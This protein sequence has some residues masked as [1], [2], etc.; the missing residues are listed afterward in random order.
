M[1]I[2]RSLFGHF[3]PKDCSG[4]PEASLEECLPGGILDDLPGEQVWHAVEPERESEGQCGREEVRQVVV[5]ALV[6]FESC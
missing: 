4:L 3:I 1:Y 6:V 5:F 2:Q